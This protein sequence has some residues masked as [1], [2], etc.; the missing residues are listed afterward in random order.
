[1]SFTATQYQ[2]LKQRGSQAV[3]G[4]PGAGQMLGNRTVT[5]PHAQVFQPHRVLPLWR[6]LT[7]YHT[8]PQSQHPELRAFTFKLYHLQ[9]ILNNVHMEIDEIYH[10][11]SVTD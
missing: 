9:I 8:M 4:S 7:T 1:M 5:S 2:Y 11:L 3:P 6:P 10:T